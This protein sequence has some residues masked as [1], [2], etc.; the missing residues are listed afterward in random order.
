MVFAAG[1]GAQLVAVPRYSDFPAQAAVLPQSARQ[2]FDFLSVVVV[3]SAFI[4]S[5]RAF[6]ETKPRRL[7]A[8]LYISQ[9]SFILAGIAAAKR[10]QEATTP[11]SGGAEARDAD[12]DVV[13]MNTLNSFAEAMQGNL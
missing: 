10:A 6:A 11:Q 5:I 8:F 2:A 13:D 4:I 9:A 3:V 1:A 7:L 12:G